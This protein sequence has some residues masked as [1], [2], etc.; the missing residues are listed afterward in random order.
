MFATVFLMK[1]M[2]VG[3]VSEKEPEILELQHRMIVCFREA[4]VD[5]DHI[6]SEIANLLG[7]V[8]PAFPAVPAQVHLEAALDPTLT[9]GAGAGACAGADPQPPVAPIPQPDMPASL[10]QADLFA[11]WGFDPVLILA[12][13]D[14]FIQAVDPSQDQ[15]E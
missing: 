15:G 1:A 5:D 2:S 4:A 9:A 12:E 3:A 11:N 10:G 13:M 6:S 8:F 14:D 7:R